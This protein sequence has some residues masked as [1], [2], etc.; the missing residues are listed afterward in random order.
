MCRLSIQARLSEEGMLI[1][2]GFGGRF[3]GRL[4]ANH[5]AVPDAGARTPNPHA[6]ICQVTILP[7]FT[8]VI[9]MTRSIEPD[10]SEA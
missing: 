1:P 7:V 8:A 4:L 10:V 9:S 5:A 6:D 3:G 2:A